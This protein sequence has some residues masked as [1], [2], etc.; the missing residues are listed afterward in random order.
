M[1]VQSLKDRVVQLIP[2]KQKELKEVTAKY[3]EKG[4]GEVTVSQAI[5]GARDVKCMFWETS[6]LDSHEVRKPCLAVLPSILLAA[7]RA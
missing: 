2:A 7:S 6:L 4:L 5:G 1:Y 3:G